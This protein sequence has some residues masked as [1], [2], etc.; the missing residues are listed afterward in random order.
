MTHIPNEIVNHIIGY[1]RPK[2]KYVYHLTKICKIAE[3][4]TA[5]GKGNCRVIDY[6]ANVRNRQR[7]NKLKTFNHYS[8]LNQLKRL[9]FTYNDFKETSGITDMCLGEWY[10]IIIDGDT[11]YTSGDENYESD[12]SYSSEDDDNNDY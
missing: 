3:Y 2:P 10:K 8:L 4:Y 11:L 7:L 6:M 5:R 9:L 12:E 1:A